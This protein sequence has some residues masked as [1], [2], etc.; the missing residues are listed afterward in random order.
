[1]RRISAVD[2]WPKDRPRWVTFPADNDYLRSVAVLAR[3]IADL[4]EEML[5]LVGT[6]NGPHVQT[7][8]SD[9]RA[10]GA[11]HL[12]VAGGHHQVRGVPGT[13]VRRMQV[14]P[15]PHDVHA[16]PSGKATRT[17]R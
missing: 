1:M 2:P 5:R 12:P 9:S 6:P 4:A 13:G 11:T 8:A 7:P 14:P 17:V 16:S 15:E 10:P 3:D